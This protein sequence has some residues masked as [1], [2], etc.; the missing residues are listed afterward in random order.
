MK[1]RLRL[2][3]NEEVAAVRSWKLT[4]GDVRLGSEG[5]NI[6]FTGVLLGG[7]KGRARCGGV[8]CSGPARVAQSNRGTYQLVVRSGLRGII[9]F[10]GAA[11]DNAGS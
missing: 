5:L 10:D 7:G 2:R 11:K 1:S 8:Q 6:R 4:G 9:N 3:V